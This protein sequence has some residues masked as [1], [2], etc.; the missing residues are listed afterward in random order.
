MEWVQT[1]GRSIAEAKEAALDQLG[2]AEDDAEFEVL[3][4]PRAG[5]FGRVR[6][7]ARVRARVRPTAPRAKN[8]R[9]DRKKPETAGVPDSVVG[10]EPASAPR[11]STS[12]SRSSAPRE[13]REQRERAPREPR[14]SSEPVDPKAVGDQAVTFLDGLV[15][16]F[17]LAGTSSLHQ[18][19][20]DLEITVD[21]QDLG[22]LVGPRGATL[23]A[24]QDVTRVASQRRL[25]DHSTHLRVDIAGYRAKRR[26]A[27]TRFTQKV[28]DEVKA[29]G[30]ARSLE[31]MPSADRKV[32]H[33]AVGALSGVSSRSDGEEPNRRVVIVPSAD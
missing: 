14:E 20:E 7:E 24:I 30:T 16:A 32:I 18:E 6:G 12:P 1:T 25:G 10:A 5:L 15:S 13:P 26:E 11:R 29:T 33:D 8:E 3:D 4:E 17:G 28:V 23:L 21:G 27:L 9:R 2:V 19:G 22:I 31:A